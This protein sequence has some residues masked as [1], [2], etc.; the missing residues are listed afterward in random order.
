MHRIPAIGIALVVLASIVSPRSLAAQDEPGAIA[1]SEGMT[2]L[3]AGE[4]WNARGHFERAIREGY[5][6]G[7]A[8]RALADAYLA[9]DN[10]LFYAREA[11][12]RAVEARPDDVEAWYLLA[13]VNL[14]L[15]GGDA[16]ER[17]RDAFHGIFRL[18]PFHRDAWERWR[19]LYLDRDDL[20]TTAAILGDHLETSYDPEI[21]LRRIDTL[22]QVGEYEAVAR[23][24]ERFGS[25]VD[26][27]A[28]WTARLGYYDGVVRAALEEP[29]T[30]G[31]RYFEGLAA[32][33]S[34]ADLAPYYADVEPLLDD[35]E[36]AAWDEKSIEER[37]AF[38]QGWWNERD[39]LPLSGVRE[40]W[41]EQQS[42]IREARQSYKWNKPIQKEKLLETGGRD[43]GMP[44]IA[45]RL[46]GRPLADRG[47]VYLRHGEPDQWDRGR[48]DPCGFWYFTREGL[49]DGEIGL[50]FTEGDRTMVGSRGQFFGNDCN[51][52]TV[53]HTPLGL[54]ILGHGPVTQRGDL[55][56]IQGR[57]LEYLEVGLSTDTYDHEIENEL[58]VLGDPAT[59]AF[60]G[61]GTEVVVY[62]AVPL[63][64]VAVEDARSRYRKGIVVYDE[65]WSEIERRTE[66]MEG[67]ALPGSVGE[68]ESRVLLDLFGVRVEPGTV[69][70]AVQVDDLQGDGVGVWREEIDVP[71]Y[72]PVDLAVSDVVFASSVS[73]DGAAPRFRR[74]GHTV[75]PVPSRT[76]RRGESM[77]LYYETY[78]LAIGEDGRARFRIEY[79]VRSDR[80]DR[81]A[82]ERVFGAI[83]DLVGVTEDDESITFAFEREIE[84]PGEIVPEFLSLDTSRLEGGEYS[85]KLKLID[86]EREDRE[87]ARERTFRIVE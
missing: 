72:P 35:E 71:A 63:G 10:R 47:A 15:D 41:A 1:F 82:L 32:A 18:D 6:P 33:R 3:E 81:G 22:V 25:R 34:E 55:P 77:V 74:H 36:R 11:L 23:E 17:A 19:R 29:A 56:E 60:L 24:I 43:S 68:D 28:P 65:S 62:F 70:L 80:L 14:R 53:P 12:E 73:L 26:D 7:R 2:A 51:F 31:A 59:F 13:D 61:E 76:F 20:R 58:D 5:P 42:R 79:T 46:H 69:H 75:L 67:V 54:E 9:L 21:A 38:L 4:A 83:G 39:P 52:S 30:G 8:Y 87:V 64:E 37:R 50:S 66:R 48:G 49:P 86:H 16:D 27:R 44:A 78:H 40:R 45:I 57:A 84:E 85:L